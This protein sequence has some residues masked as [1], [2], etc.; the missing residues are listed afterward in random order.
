MQ[1]P[2]GQHGE[3]DGEA[4]G[5]VGRAHA[6]EGRR[7]GAVEHAAAVTEQGAEA[8]GEVETATLELDQVRD[9][10]GGG[11]PGAGGEAATRAINTSSVRV[12]GSVINMTRLIPSRLD[13]EGPMRPPKLK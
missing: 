1:R 3:D 6:V 13:S 8:A 2:R 12:V 4:A 7:L 5:G 9:E 11:L 10:L